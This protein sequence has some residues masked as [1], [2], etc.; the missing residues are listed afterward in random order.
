MVS[1]DVEDNP[2]NSKRDPR[3]RQIYKR[4]KMLF[5]TERVRK[6]ILVPATP[7]YSRPVR[8]CAETNCEDSWIQE[9]NRPRKNEAFGCPMVDLHPLRLS[10]YP[11]RRNQVAPNSRL[12][13]SV[14]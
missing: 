5:S 9:P 14:R 6:E 3:E 11:R 13:C 10:S 7:G 1:L 4:R 8:L 12:Q 2:R